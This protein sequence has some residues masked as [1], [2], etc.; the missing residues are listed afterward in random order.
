MNLNSSSQKGKS[1]EISIRHAIV[2]WLQ[3][4]ALQQHVYDTQCAEEYRVEDATQRITSFKVDKN[5]RLT[6]SK[7]P[8]HKDLKL[9]I[10]ANVNLQS[11]R[12][13]EYIA[14]R[15][16]EIRDAMEA[17]VDQPLVNPDF[18]RRASLSKNAVKEFLNQP[19]KHYGEK[20]ELL[21]DIKRVFKS[22]LYLGVNIAY[23]KSG[24]KYSHIFS[25]EVAGDP[26][27]LVVREYDDGV[28]CLYSCSDNPK[29]ATGLIKIKRL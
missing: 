25:I 10:Q 16:R 28:C 26:S 6:V 19:H 21:L 29:I 20:N 17:E 15:R 24:V 2:N 7:H 9:A 13:H 1:E 8:Y 18:Q 5:L 3:K 12:E 27:W 23:N 11:K 22:A 14:R 4:T